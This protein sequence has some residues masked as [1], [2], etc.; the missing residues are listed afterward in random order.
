MT[1]QHPAPT[2][3]PG[4]FREFFSIAYPLVISN[5][6]VTL[7]TFVDRLF[8]SWYSPLDIAASLPAGILGYTLIAFFLGV[9]E[10][11]NTF[12][13]QF[14]GAKRLSDVARATWQGLWL[15]IGSGIFSLFLLPV[16]NWILSVGGH[17]P[18]VVIREKTYFFYLMFALIFQV[19][20]AALSSF[21]SGRGRTKVIMAVSIV[22]NIVNCVLDYALIFGVWGFPEWGIKGAAVATFLSTAFGTVLYLCLFLSPENNRLYQTRST[23][24][25]DSDLIKRILRYGAPSG[26]EFLLSISSFTVFIFLI[27]RLGTIELAASNIVLAINMLAFLPMLGASVATATLVG[28]YIGRQDYATAEK[29]AYTAFY[30]VQF[31][32][33][34]FALIYFFF[35]E[36]LI[37]L[38]HSTETA[39]E[40]PFEN[41]VS[42]GTTIL[43]LVAIYQIFDAM[44]I[45]FMGALRGAGDTTFAMW[46]SVV[47]AWFL[48]VPGTWILLNW[49]GRGVIG[50]WMWATFYIAVAGLVYLFRF[51]SGYW[52]SI[53]LIPVG[54]EPPLPTEAG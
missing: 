25:L 24:T 43:M 13:A 17:A 40:I 51:R 7:M 50:A 42:Y 44:I 12:V 22:I 16:G 20:N 45:T 38:F 15:A 41:I 33:L 26:M 31:Y 52:K 14:Y 18:E 8:L 21:Y 54:E 19:I 6:S 29:S 9:S 5:G 32:M 46:A 34:A 30:S 53:R 11:T 35:P 39:V 49:M 47:C 36:T 48:F 27:G 28:Q 2:W 1:D 23:F 4:G 3:I 10:Y 37:R